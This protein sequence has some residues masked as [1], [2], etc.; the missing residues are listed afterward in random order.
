MDVEA[1]VDEGG[2]CPFC[3]IRTATRED[4]HYHI[5]AVHLLAHAQELS[6]QC[7]TCYLRFTR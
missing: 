5:A 4:V 6:H 2:V 7:A 1:V 3:R